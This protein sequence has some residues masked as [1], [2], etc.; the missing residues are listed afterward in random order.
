[1]LNKCYRTTWQ[2]EQQQLI[3]SARPL[4]RAP[5]ST[6]WG[7]WARPLLYTLGHVTRPPPAHSIESTATTM[8][9]VCHT[10][11]WIYCRGTVPPLPRTRAGTCCCQR[12]PNGGDTQPTHHGL[13]VMPTATYM[14]ATIHLL[15]PKV[16]A[17]VIRMLL[18]HIAAAFSHNTDA[19]SSNFSWATSKQ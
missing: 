10:P 13:H 9:S 4:S 8:I 16:I 18:P 14:V 5:S 2:T 7:M 19:D 12:S 11:S 3:C 1:M 15:L 6:L 17:A